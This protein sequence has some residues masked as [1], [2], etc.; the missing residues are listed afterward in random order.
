MSYPYP[1]EI[2]A[3]TAEHA[4]PPA[5]RAD[6]GQLDVLFVLNNLGVGGSERKI[7]RLAQRLRSE[8][9]RAAIACLNE[10]YTLAPSL[11]PEI[12]LWKIGRRGKV[13]L[14]AARRLCALIAQHRP[15]HTVAVNLYPSLY[16]TLAAAFAPRPRTHT[17]TLVNSWRFTLAPWRRSFYRALL[18]LTD[19]TVHG[20]RAQRGSWFRHGAA[21]WQRSSVIYNG[22]DLREFAPGQTRPATESL[23]A[24]CAIPS[25]RLVVGSVGRLA[26][27]KN[28]RALLEA[29]AQLT[30]AN[31]DVHLLLAGDGPSGAE[32]ARRTAELGIA[33]RVS[34]IGAVEDVRPA[35]ALMDVFVLP[36]LTET[37]SNAALEAMAM[38]KPVI[39]SDVGGAREMI[40]DGIEGFVVS[41]A[42][43][44]ARLPTI[45]AA[46]SADVT[47]REHMGA[48]A[49][50]R[51]VRCFSLESM[52]AN[53]RGL[54]GPGLSEWRNA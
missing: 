40:D 29:V 34:F 37:F 46:L 53:Y 7:V 23:R 21:A 38:G 14:T 12:P 25:G 48:A 36:S 13:S 52:V 5:A 15:L 45:L 16:V 11:G 31:V 20:S 3:G 51:V 30:A 33:R 49:R 10:P 47:R 42:E 44:R 24:R 41:L 28:Q 4:S 32:L 54:F 26:P 17:I 50:S 8:G 2:T 27:E 18:S 6:A 19:H 35:L 43:L 22:V 9:A 1:I 39:L